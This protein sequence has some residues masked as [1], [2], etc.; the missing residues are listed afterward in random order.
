MKLLFLLALGGILGTLARYALQGWLQPAGGTFPWGTL[1]V[2]ILGSFALGFLMR[3]LLG[4]GVASPEWRAMATIGFCGAFTT[5]ST[6]A[7]ET[8]ALLQSA[9]YLP[10]AGYVVSSMAGSLAGVVA[11][12]AA[13]GKLL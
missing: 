13:G 11:G 2:N 5:M 12:M 10:A 3:F 9:R 1:A 4:S 8:I 6:F 7:Y